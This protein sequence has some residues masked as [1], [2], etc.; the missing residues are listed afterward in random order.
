M[1]YLHHL[2]SC[3]SSF[4]LFLLCIMPTRRHHLLTHALLDSNSYRSEPSSDSS[5]VSTEDPQQLHHL[6]IAI[7]DIIRSMD[8]SSVS[9][10]SELEC[11]TVQNRDP[12]QM[13]F[14]LAAARTL[15]S[16]TSS[17]RRQYLSVL[18][19]EGLRRNRP[20]DAVMTVDPFPTANFG[21][22]VVIFT[23]DLEVSFEDC[24]S[25]GGWY[26]GE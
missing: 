18:P 15:E 25:K 12:S 24:R 20:H 11:L 22:L 10:T 6:A 9:F 3:S 26:I 4:F 7:L 1:K 2:W 5:S 16:S 19:D 8:C 23:L 17:S 21:H 13:N 14:Y